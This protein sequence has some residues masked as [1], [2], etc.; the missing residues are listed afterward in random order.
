MM[1]GF[2]SQGTLP[3]Y[4]RNVLDACGGYTLVLRRYD[5]SLNPH[6]NWHDQSPSLV[7]E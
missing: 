3:F 5:V 7:H 6:T 1:S 2:S 4:V